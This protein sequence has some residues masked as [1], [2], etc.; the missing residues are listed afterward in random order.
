[1]ILSHISCLLSTVSAVSYDFLI[2]VKLHH[3][4]LIVIAIIDTHDI[5]TIDT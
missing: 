4:F 1:M 3:V 5:S 2:A